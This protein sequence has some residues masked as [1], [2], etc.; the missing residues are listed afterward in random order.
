MEEGSQKRERFNGRWAFGFEWAF[1]WAR[2]TGILSDYYDVF[3]NT[4]CT[5]STLITGRIGALTTG[6]QTQVTVK[7]VL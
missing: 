6:V 5:S 2:L 7:E 3:C 1:L 4:S